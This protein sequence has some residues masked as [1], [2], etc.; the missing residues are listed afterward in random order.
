MNLNN[1][2]IFAEAKKWFSDIDNHMLHKEQ[3]LI[4]QLI[5]Q[6]LGN[7][8][9]HMGPASLDYE[10]STKFIKLGDSLTD[11]DVVCAEHALPIIPAYIDAFLLQHTLDFCI[12]PNQVLQQ[13]NICLRDGGQ[14]IIVGLNPG[15]VLGVKRFFINND[16]LKNARF[17]APSLVVSMLNKLNFTLTHKIFI[18]DHIF[19]SVYI[20][21]ARK[22]SIAPHTQVVAEKNFS[23][24]FMPTTSSVVNKKET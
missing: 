22:I 4:N 15:S 5:V 3:R 9:V 11:C 20:V 23:K 6:I 14:L 12:N 24:I 7:Y 17:L 8:W 19:G 18:D 13:V 2:N 21:I 1:F 16:I 10:L